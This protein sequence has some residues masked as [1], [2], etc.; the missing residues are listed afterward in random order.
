MTVYWQ[1]IFRA[2][3]QVFL[4]KQHLHFLLLKMTIRQISIK[5]AL[6]LLLPISIH[7]LFILETFQV[8]LT[9]SLLFGRVLKVL[10]KINNI[11]MLLTSKL[12]KDNISLTDKSY[13][14]TLVLQC[15]IMQP[16]SDGTVQYWQWTQFQILVNLPKWYIQVF[17]V[18]M[19]VGILI[20][21]I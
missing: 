19:V 8:Y 13:N 21:L 11:L 7:N 2:S 15:K 17:L 14:T 18:K 3:T 9:M 12:S 6:S 4:A 10:P 16:N 20:T 1:Y 5:L